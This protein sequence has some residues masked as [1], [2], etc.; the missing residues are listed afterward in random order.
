VTFAWASCLVGFPPSVF[1]EF[2]GRFLD[3]LGIGTVAWFAFGH[4]SAWR[5][6]IRPN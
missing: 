1:Q 5:R 6:T 2:E 3:V 4:D